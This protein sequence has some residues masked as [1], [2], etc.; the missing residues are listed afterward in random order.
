MGSIGKLATTGLSTAIAQCRRLVGSQFFK[1]SFTSVSAQNDN[2][3]NIKTKLK[4]TFPKAKSIEIEDISGGC[5]SMYEI[6]IES[7]D[8]SSMRT[9]AQHKLVTD[10]LKDEVKKL[11]GL[12]IFTT[13]PK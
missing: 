12:R 7:E 3:D 4:S 5:G 13:V 9:V 1:Q 6:H 10:A 11:H 8:F 2:E